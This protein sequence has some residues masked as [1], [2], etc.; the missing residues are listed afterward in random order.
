M[1][2]KQP[3]DHSRKAW[4]LFG[5][6]NYKLL[7]RYLYGITGLLCAACSTALAAAGNLLPFDSSFETGNG[8]APVASDATHAW[9]GKYALRLPA[10]MTGGLTVRVP[11]IKKAHREYVFSFY[12]M[13]D[14]PGDIDCAVSN[15]FWGNSAGARIRVEKE[16]KRFV[17]RLPAEKHT[18]GIGINFRKP[19][20]VSVWL[21]AFSLTEG[22]DVAAYAPSSAVSVGFASVN[23]LDK[24]VYL[25]DQPLT[26]R[27]GVRNNTDK[28]QKLQVTG[29][30]AGF[31]QKSKELINAVLTLAPGELWEK[32]VV[33][34]E[35]KQR[36][37]Y[38]MRITAEADG[39]K[40]NNSQPVVVLDPCL[41][42]SRESFFGLHFCDGY[43]GI[44]GKKI[45]ASI[46]R[47]FDHWYPCRP[48]KDG[49]YQ[50][51]AARI[52]NLT[53][54]EGMEQ[55]RC[56]NLNHPPTVIPQK[57]GLAKNP[58]DVEKWALALAEAYRGYINFVELHNEPDLSFQNRPDEYAAL[59]NRLAPAIRKTDPNFKILASG[60]SGVDFNNHFQYTRQIL[61]QAGKNIDIVAVHPYTSNHYISPEG[62]DVSPEAGNMYEKTMALK[63]IIRELGGRQPVWYGEVGWGVD[64]REDY[65]SDC[66][67]RHAA[68]LVRTM[69]VGMAAG[70]EKCTYFPLND[71]IEKES[72]NYGLWQFG[73]PMPAVG[74]Y[75]AAVQVLEKAKFLGI[76]NNRDLH[77]YLFR[78]RD[79]RLFFAVWVSTA[80]KTVFKTELDP[81]KVEVRDMMNNPVAIDSR[82]PVQ[83]GLSGDVLYGFVR[84]MTVEQLRDV[85]T[86]AQYELPPFRINWS[87]KSGSELQLGLTNVRTQT[88]YGTVE[89]AGEQ[90]RKSQQ[91]FTVPP[92]ETVYLRFS[93]TAGLNQQTLKLTGDCNAGKFGSSFF[94]ETMPCVSGTPIL[95]SGSKLPGYGRLPKMDSRKYLL[96]NDP[97]NGWT[98]PE[99]LSVDSV[100]CYDRDN[101]YLLADVRD[102]VHW[103]KAEPGR[104]WS[105]D[106]IQLAIDTGAN[107]TPDAGFDKDDYEFGFGLTPS[108]PQKEL[109]YIYQHGRAK[110]ALTA[111]KCNI[112][113]QGDRTCYR[114]AIPWDALKMKPEKGAVFGLNFT[115]NDHDGTGM[116]FYMGLAPGIVEKKN[117]YVYRKFYLEK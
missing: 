115:V 12:A 89:I 86:R 100:L 87:L 4:N 91:A 105:G 32:T 42:V 60:V 74:A 23:P 77:C 28:P 111:V 99:N 59:V 92:G 3:N 61:T 33:V 95:L 11:L 49:R 57:D 1:I 2:L 73:Q 80:D 15:D 109:T 103:Q 19:S 22:K 69:L 94:C 30:I 39:K 113:R 45:G 78:H 90:F 29:S 20:G 108:V 6:K 17:L 82:K 64:V 54:K 24:L 84:D 101:L 14:T 68:Y 31:N 117:P 10:G 13:S 26:T 50:I 71:V 53:E 112:F 43:Y 63:K 97:E 79:G 65:L 27:M 16:W 76:V 36:G 8:G 47:T 67:L 66:A 44:K 93:A 48:D 72:Q 51:D 107:A 98:G 5:S 18:T 96:P 102:D 114:I 106:S 46:S 40:Y 56:I 25:D 37:Y 55:L 110:A 116:R 41:P 88:L 75:A 52:R 62:G 38:V 35:R 7:S 85:L 104:L 58:A 70:V 9:N 83:L 21:D 34:Q 81:R